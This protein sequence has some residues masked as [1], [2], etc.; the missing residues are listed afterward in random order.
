MS[1]NNTDEHLRDHFV[2]SRHL[3]FTPFYLCFHCLVSLIIYKF[4]HFSFTVF[5]KLLLIF[6]SFCTRK[7]SKKDNLSALGDEDLGN[8]GVSNFIVQ[9]ALVIRGLSICGFDYSRLKNCYQNLLF[10]VLSLG[11]SRFRENFRQN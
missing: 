5:P 2:L 11:N 9:A 6:Y 7:F 4:Y 1:I 10:A 8:T 3:T